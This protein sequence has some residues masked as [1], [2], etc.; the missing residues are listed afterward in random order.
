ME[1]PLRHAPQRLLP[2]R[3]RRVPIG[4]HRHRHARAPALK[5]RGLV[6][7]LPR[8]GPAPAALEERL[9]ARG[10]R[11]A[12]EAP[13]LVAHDRGQET[14]GVAARGLRHEPVDPV[15]EARLVLRAEV[16]VRPV[17][18]HG[19]VPHPGQASEPVER[20]VADAVVDGVRRVV[21]G[22]LDHRVE[23]GPLAGVGCPV[24]D[25]AEVGHQQHRLHQTRAHV[26]PTGREAVHASPRVDERPRV[27]ASA[28]T[29]PALDRAQAPDRGIARRERAAAHPA[30]RPG[31]TRTATSVR[32]PERTCTCR[33]QRSVG[34]SSSPA[35]AVAGALVADH[36]VAAGRK[37]ALHPK[38]RP[39]HA[40]RDD[41]LAAHPAHAH[42]RERPLHVETVRAVE[43]LAQVECPR[44]R[45][46]PRRHGHERSQ[47]G[48]AVPGAHR[49]AWY[50]CPYRRRNGALLA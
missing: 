42:V 33:A 39:I 30:R 7:Q 2:I 19:E 38:T 5:Q 17:A 44:R 18:G 8:A 36:L 24:S 21:R 47:D 41:E 22:D 35:V 29:E 40:L 31:R 26:H 15:E 3:L 49:T 48:Y 34:G 10:E 14:A 45:V 32:P 46:G 25:P 23:R 11:I 20:R 12:R 13:A 43:R 37:P 1:H 16:G 28:R 4:E 9:E 50:G 6:H 27:D